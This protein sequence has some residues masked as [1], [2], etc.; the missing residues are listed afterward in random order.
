MVGG[1]SFEAPSKSTSATAYPTEICHSP[2]APTD[3]FTY[4]HTTRLHRQT[5]ALTGEAYIVRSLPSRRRPRTR[6][7]SRSSIVIGGRVDASCPTG[8][9]LGNPLKPPSGVESVVFTP[10]G[11]RWPP[12][13]PLRASSCGMHAP[14]AARRPPDLETTRAYSRP[15]QQDAIDALKLPD[16]DQG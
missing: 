7:R 16:T 10:T 4:H 13:V 5:D 12:P 15:T 9:P 3:H 11:T 6:P 1:Y 2:L 8:E 14:Q